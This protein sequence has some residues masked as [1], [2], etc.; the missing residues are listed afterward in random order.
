MSSASVGA[1]PV[2]TAR[3]SIEGLSASTT[4]RTSLVRGTASGRAG[5]SQD[6]Q[7]GVFALGPAASR[8]E[9][10]DRPG[11]GDQRDRRGEDR[12]A[13]QRERRA[14]GVERERG[15]GGGVQASGGAGEQ[16]QGGGGGE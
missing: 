16:R 10:P 7:P 2:A 13:G 3:S 4:Q 15:A 8:Q 14:L 11:E 5:S 9:E 1:R 6:A 12:Q